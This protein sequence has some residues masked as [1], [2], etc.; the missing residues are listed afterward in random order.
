MINQKTY[1]VI[2]DPS[3]GVFDEPGSWA[4][5]REAQGLRT[6]F[7]PNPSAE[8]SGSD[9]WFQGGTYPSD[10]IYPERSTAK[11]WIGEA[12]FK[13]TSDTAT[14]L[15]EQSGFYF[16]P[17]SLGI[18]TVSL[19]VKKTGKLDR[20]EINVDDIDNPQYVLYRDYNHNDATESDWF[21]WAYS[22]EVF[23]LTSK[24]VRFRSSS[25][26]TGEEFVVYMDGILIEAGGGVG[27]YFDGSTDFAE[28][29]GVPNN[30][31]S[32]I[33]Y[34]RQEFADFGFVMTALVGGNG[35]QWNTISTPYAFGGGY[36]QRSTPMMTEFSIVG[37][38]E[39]TGRIDLERKRRAFGKA[40]S[41]RLGLPIKLVYQPKT[42]ED[43]SWT[44]PVIVEA[45]YMSGLEGN[46][47]N[48]FQETVALNFRIHTPYVASDV[49]S[50]QQ[51]VVILKSI[52]VRGG[53][54]RRDPQGV[55][56]P[57]PYLS[58]GAL[59]AYARG[60]DGLLRAAYSF[61]A[62]DVKVYILDEDNLVAS[63]IGSFTA[64]SSSPE[65]CRIYHLRF[66][67]DGN[68][69]AAG[70]FNSI[71]GATKN[72][73]A[74]W[75]GAVWTSDI[76]S[77]AEG[78]ASGVATVQDIAWITDG[79]AYIVGNFSTINGNARKNF[80]R[81]TGGTFAAVS[82]GFNGSFGDT[83]PPTISLLVDRNDDLYVYGRFSGS[84]GNNNRNWWRYRPRTGG[85][86]SPGHVGAVDN[87]EIADAIFLMDGS[88]L[89]IGTFT[90]I[91]GDSI[92]GYA[93]WHGMDSY[94]SVPYLEQYFPPSRVSQN[95]NGWI[96][97]GYPT[98]GSYTGGWIQYNNAVR[99]RPEYRPMVAAYTAFALVQA[100]PDGTIY[101]WG[102]PDPSFN[103][104][105]IPETNVI[106]NEGDVN[107][108]PEFLFIG[109]L[110]VFNITNATTG[111]TMHFDLQLADGD[112]A[113]LTLYPEV[114][115]VSTIRGDITKAVLAGS[116]TRDFVLLPGA[117]NINFGADPYGETDTRIIVSWVNYYDSIGAAFE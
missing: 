71:N 25:Y 67:H 23:T 80:A 105:E 106:I 88:I 91:K 17:T 47:T 12:S 115:L 19:Y 35:P 34:T 103:D 38:I 102:V 4:V 45:V 37:T 85:F 96:E 94:E 13:Q 57:M 3:S 113:K 107:T 63:L 69:W 78:Y 30:S 18:H 61:A 50:N 42:C 24:L 53:L 41:P 54:I 9:G 99:I 82:P 74:M 46:L 62:N 52:D 112:V 2:P 97:L 79:T 76:T 21:R 89:M 55:Y 110:N 33:D 48:E 31:I 90:A 75:D 65:P 117:N 64:T 20:F 86:Y 16:T 14:E 6:N 83:L 87:D 7:A 73:L 60:N 93:I 66:D 108:W 111:K 5:L 1:R 77:I 27:D 98:T 72:N 59:T 44:K 28:W 92:T 101:L 29:H 104:T 70:N 95:P 8:A 56:H 68:L 84:G 49:N 114:K 81:Y 51:N 40:L 36:Y 116:Q 26:T 11:H 15:Y 22:F 43:A 100:Y 32:S 58:G 10:V 39:A 109:L